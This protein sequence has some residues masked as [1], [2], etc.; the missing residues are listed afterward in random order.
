MISLIHPSRS[1]VSRSMQTYFDWIDSRSNEIEIQH[2]ISIDESDPDIESYKEHFNRSTLVIGNNTCAVEAI[3]H[4]AKYALG[5]I[6]IVISD[7][8]K[9]RPGWDKKIKSVFDE[10][11]SLDRIIKT[12]DGTQPWIITLPIM[13]IDFY[14]RQGYVYNPE[15]RHMFCDT[16]L[17][18][19]A[20]LES[21]SVYRNDILFKHNHYS[22]GA[23]EPDAVSRNADSTWDQG[24]ALYLRNVRNNFGL[25]LPEGKSVFDIKLPEGQGHLQWLK[26]KLSI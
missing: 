10:I 7:D 8:F 14:N 20:D 25:S 9:C 13:G 11:G 17:T 23:A 2:I 26:Q 16:E 5:E 15:Y 24:M 21:K 18:H 12:S 19:R 1:R 3:N 6:I 22:T 4:G